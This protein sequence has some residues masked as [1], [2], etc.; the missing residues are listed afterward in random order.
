MLATTK[1]FVGICSSSFEKAFNTHIACTTTPS[2]WV[3]S[4]VATLEKEV[5]GA[6]LGSTLA[7]QTMIIVH[8]CMYPQPNV[9]W[10]LNDPSKRSHFLDKE[11]FFECYFWCE[12]CFKKKETFRDLFKHCDYFSSIGWHFV[13]EYLQVLLCCLLHSLKKFTCY[14][15]EERL[16]QHAEQR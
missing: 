7:W 5:F 9:S 15:H 13:P 10:C 16:W 6:N 12:K 14:F 2:C 11:P 4:S 3:G 1:S 8:S